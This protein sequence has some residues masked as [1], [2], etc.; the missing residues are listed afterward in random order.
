MDVSQQADQQSSDSP[1][2]DR[3]AVGPAGTV[4]APGADAPPPIP[5]GVVAELLSALD[6]AVRAKRLYQDNNPVYHGFIRSLT[7]SIEQL[8]EPL[9]ALGITVEEHAFV[10]YGHRFPAG[11]GR[12]SLPY[13][14]YK[15]GVRQLN[16][17]PGFEDEVERFLDV[18]NRMRLADPSE[19]EDMVTLLWQ[20][21]FTS[22]QY[23]YVD[24][25]AEGIAMPDPPA[26]A[27]G[28]GAIAPESVRADL[29]GDDAAE[30]SPLVRSGQPTVAASITREDFDETTY[31][32]D[33]DEIERLRT[34]VAVEMQRDVKVAVLHALFDRLADPMPKRQQ[35]IL[36]ILRQL[37]PVYLGRGDLGAASQI[38]TELNAVLASDS[39][40]EAERADVA[41]LFRE[42]SDP[43]VLGQL[44]RALAEG[45]IDPTSEQLGAFLAHLGPTALPLLLQ[46]AQ[47]TEDP[48]LTERLT[49]A[50]EKLAAEHPA[51]L[52]ALLGSGE[53][54]V[55]V[56][57]ARLIGRLGY[58]AAAG[59]LRG[60]LEH[61]DAGVRLA[62]T[63]ALAAI[64][65][66]AAIE[67]LRLTLRDTD[68]EVRIAGA[69]G[70]GALRYTP[71]RGW[72]E[73]IV[74]SRE[75]RD[76]DL[77][78]QMAVFEAYGAVAN[79]QCVPLLDRMLNGRRLL[80]RESPEIRACAALAL[81]R[82]GSPTAME[83]LRRASAESQP[84]IR[85][86]VAKA[87]R[88]K[89]AR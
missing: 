47:R 34:E 46:T 32:L 23:S 75:I 29:R 76:A 43:L 89:P 19:D 67:G 21:E 42:L 61:A 18:I 83:A 77:T 22:F 72:L 88:E 49:I 86:A 82:I 44:L 39:L 30:T 41:R 81:G 36:R 11:D 13:L 84:I 51:E 7:R 50:T 3:V 6:K 70:L 62:A 8:W 53:S 16:F 4:P 1:S 73:E 35:E 15:D 25:L 63:E 55:L 87:L 33:A 31:F 37:L 66:S 28:A 78:E 2:V 5:P 45:S 12:D 64:G 74:E 52:A 27:E 48:V 60:L 56:G 68:R 26:L 80:G 65:S 59:T 71:A 38:V 85:N 14:F 57:A 40:Q 9:A 79:A 20:Q 69:R 54:D 24:A 17:L 58:A 10:W